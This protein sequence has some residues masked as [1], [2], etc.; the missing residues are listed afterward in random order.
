VEEVKEKETRG[1]REKGDE[2]E[3]K[4]AEERV[5]ESRDEDGAE[6]EEET[7]EDGKAKAKEERK[8]EEVKRAKAERREREERVK[9][10]EEEGKREKEQ[11]EGE[12]TKAKTKEKREAKGEDGEEKEF[13]EKEGTREG[14]GEVVE[15]SRKAKAGAEAK[16]SQEQAQEPAPAAPSVRRL[17]RELGIDINQVPGSGP[18]GRISEE[19]VKNFARWIITRGTTAGGDVQAAV[20]TVTPAPL[21]DFTQWG[22]VERKAMTNV[23]RKTAEVMFASWTAV[24]HVTQH[25]KAD[26]TNIEKLRKEFGKKAEEAGGKLT[27]TAILLKVVAMALKI[28]PQFNA[29]VDMD[30][31]EIV[32]KKYYN[33]GVAVDTERGL[34]VPVI[35]DVDKKNVI[36][37]SVELV[38]LSEKTR[39][40]KISM[41]DL[42]GGTFTISNQGSI[43]G[44][45]FSPIINW[46]E[47]AILG[48]SRGRMEPVYVN[49]QFEPRLML[50][51][52]LSHDHRVIDGA[53]AVRFLRWIVEALEE[54]FRLI[55]E[56]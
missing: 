32:Y 56:G 23:R 3:A 52:S 25:D 28:F 50:P 26:I 53:D 45:Y 7:K 20:P 13:R 31:E 24:P 48:I 47:V 29:S 40:R 39:N 17:A 6:S 55:L 44:I 16:P 30:K 34:Y 2:V 49:G 8:K 14:Q 46:P 36:E 51:L 43:G 10:K 35:H 41:E 38:Q 54:P 22:E 18:R 19:D 5:E 42:K 9:V 11:E 27:V 1:T 4:E 15:F 12:K 21:P 37:L 33:I